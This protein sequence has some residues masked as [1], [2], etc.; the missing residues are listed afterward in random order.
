ME[1]LCPDA[2]L[3]NLTNPMTCL[4]RAI[5]KETSIRAVGLCHEVVIMSWLVA[6]A[7]GIPADDVHFSITGVNHL[8]WIT[9]FDVAGEDGF[10]ALRRA[11]A[12]RP[13][14]AWFATD[15]QLKLAM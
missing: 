12:D 10:E 13:D 7:L 4:T 14:S 15:H 9:Q 3:M 11:V 5:N 6:I 1:Q 8:P 2:W